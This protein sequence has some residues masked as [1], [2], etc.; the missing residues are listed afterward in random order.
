LLPHWWNV[1]MR[2]IYAQNGLYSIFNYHLSYQLC[3][4]LGISE[5]WFPLRLYL[6]LFSLFGGLSRLM[7]L[8][9]CCWCFTSLQVKTSHFSSLSFPW[10]VVSKSSFFLC[11][12]GK[13]DFALSFYFT[14]RFYF[15]IFSSIWLAELAFDSCPFVP[16]SFCDLALFFAFFKSGVSLRGMVGDCW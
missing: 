11:L 12:D 8:C 2:R 3:T 14:L 5:L 15:H 7:L 13:L 6:S 4:I 10:A 1:L 9:C 16:L